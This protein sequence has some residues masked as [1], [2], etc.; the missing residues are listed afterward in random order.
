MTI[1]HVHCCVTLE[2]VIVHDCLIKETVFN[3][4]VYVQR[5]NEIYTIPWSEAEA[6]C[7]ARGMTLA[8]RADMLESR[9]LGLDIC[10]CGWISDGSCVLV[11]VTFRPGC[12]FS[13]EDTVHTCDYLEAGAYCKQI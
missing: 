9:A 1:F 10:D 11:Q 12:G 6:E 7:Q 2:M 5:P 3:A 8:S 13:N 4:V